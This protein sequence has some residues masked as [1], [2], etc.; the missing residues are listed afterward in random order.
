M[1]WSD[2]YVND[3]CAMVNKCF[4]RSILNF[5]KADE[6]K[7]SSSNASNKTINWLKT[8][9]VVYGGKKDKILVLGERN[10]STTDAGVSVLTL[11]APAVLLDSTYVEGLGE[12]FGLSRPPT[13]K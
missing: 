11:Q 5:D 12:T 1:S 2:K 13:V 4:L 10:Y 3:V 8:E 6:I 7:S 9:H